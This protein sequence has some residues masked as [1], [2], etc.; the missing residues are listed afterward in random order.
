MFHQTENYVLSPVRNHEKLDAYAMLVLL[1]IV[2]LSMTLP[3][4][5]SSILTN[6]YFSHSGVFRNWSTCLKEWGCWIMGHG[7][8]G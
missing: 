3:P 6:I 2:L 7:A 8:V 5:V 4:C 1:I